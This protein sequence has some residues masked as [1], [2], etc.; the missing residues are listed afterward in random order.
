MKAAEG[1]GGF[2][3]EGSDGQGSDSE[4]GDGEGGGSG[5]GGDEETAKMEATTAV[6]AKAEVVAK[7]ALGEGGVSGGRRMRESVNERP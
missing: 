6:A 3:G 7:A 4:G 1:E 2:G 5:G